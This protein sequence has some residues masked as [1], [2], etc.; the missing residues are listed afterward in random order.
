MADDGLSWLFELDADVSG[1]RAAMSATEQL[2]AGMKKL[3]ADTKR[4]EQSSRLAGGAHKKH[5]EEARGAGA[6][7]EGLT[8]HFE[9]IVEL[10]AEWDVAEFLLDLPK[11]IFEMGEEMVTTAAKAERMNAAFTLLQGSQVGKETL[12]YIDQIGDH[13]EFTREQLKGAALEL[14]KF[15]FSGEGMRRALAASIDL[16][17]FSGNGAAGQAEALSALERVKQ[18]GRVESR[19]LR[20]LGIN[21]GDYFKELTKRTG[22]GRAELKREMEKGTLD[23]EQSLETLYTLIAKKTGKD[24]GGAGV[25]MSTTLGAQLTHLQELPDRYAE[26][27]VGTPGYER[28]KD[29]LGDV[30]KQLDPES[31]EGRRIFGALEDVFGGLSKIIETIPWATL[32]KG[33]TDAIETVEMMFLSA[34][35]LIPGETGDKAGYALNEMKRARQIRGVDES[36]DKAMDKRAKANGTTNTFEKAAAVEDDFNDLDTASAEGLLGDKSKYYNA[37]AKTGG[38]FVDGA[39][40][41]KGIDAHSPS[42]KFEHLGRMAAAGFDGGIASSITDAASDIGDLA[43]MGTPPAAAHISGARGGNSVEMNVEVK[44]DGVGHGAR[45]L[46]EEIATHLDALLPSK[47]TSAF[48]Q[49]A[50]QGGS[51]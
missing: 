5:A 27:L 39:A 26:K 35:S 9:K 3:D 46:A 41:P 42:K 11:R 2:D 15:G 19:T 44:I 6:A 43:R 33:A 1:A 31:P 49:M 50:M 21:E 37:G 47:L 20:P 14:T 29:A 48:E 36:E 23:T 12:E 32:I 13:T 8:H 28:L 10:V 22:K 30:L 34:L 38:A 51:A 7:L 18:S 25:A 45:E 16:A 40:G 17:A 4:V 24:L